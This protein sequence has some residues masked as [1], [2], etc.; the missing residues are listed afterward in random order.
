MTWR[1]ERSFNER[2]DCEFAY[3]ETDEDAYTLVSWDP[4][5]DVEVWASLR[6]DDHGTRN[7]PAGS[8]EFRRFLRV[9][10]LTRNDVIIPSAMREST[11]P[12]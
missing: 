9:A 6:P 1:L 8:N 10:E 5:A 2:H 4:S 11:L 3:V 12:Q 7:L